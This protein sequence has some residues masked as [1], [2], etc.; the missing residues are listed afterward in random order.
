[1]WKNKKISVI[2]PAYNEEENIKDVVDD[3]SLIKEIDEIIVVDNNSN[4]KTAEEAKKTKAIVI[5]EKKQGEGNALRAGLR[6]AKGD[7]IITVESDRSFVAKD[8]YKLL[9][10]ADD[11]DMVIGTRTSKEFV[12][13]TMS[14][15]ERLGNIIMAKFMGIL[16]G[17]V[18]LTDMGCSLRLIK[19]DALNKIKDQFTVG[20]S[21]FLPEYLILALKNNLRVCEIPVN[22]NQR[23]GPSK[24]MTSRWKR[25]KIGFIILG[26]MLRYK[27]GFPPRRE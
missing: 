20:H 15:E 17:K 27:F 13:K 4:D 22:Y 1:M 9:V 24:I 26:L 8:I 16:F 11:F 3:F 25:Y 21:H 7:Y 6:I 23:R 12:S 5:K 14:S 18:S 2:F 10:Y 19:R